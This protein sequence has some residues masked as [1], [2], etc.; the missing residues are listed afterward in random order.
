VLPLDKQNEYRRRYAALNPGWQSS[1]NVFEGLVSKAITPETHWLDVGGGRG[2]LV[3]KRHAEAHTAT[4]LDPDLASL[5]EHRALAVPRTCGL[6][7]ALPY[8]ANTF[9]LV[10]ATWVLEHLPD[11]ASVFREVHRVLKPNG[12]FVFLT[13]NSYHPLLVA[14]R[15]SKL[16]P[17]LQRMIVP[18]LYARDEADTFPVQ[19]RANDAWTLKQLCDATGLKLKLYFI[20]DPTYTAFND[21]LFRVSTMIERFIPMSF[22]IHVVGVASKA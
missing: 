2:G 13:P 18:R 21:G 16:L 1:G 17:R 5:L 20:A 10:T 14:N 4:T 6:A 15:I 7:E 12:Q 19:Y 9:E 8:P 22:K 11:P 3:E